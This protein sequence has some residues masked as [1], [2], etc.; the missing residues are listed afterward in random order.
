MKNARNISR[1]ILSISFAACVMAAAVSINAQEVGDM[2]TF[3]SMQSI[4][5]HQDSQ[6]EREAAGGAVSISLGEARNT[7][8][9]QQLDFFF[10]KQFGDDFSAFVDLEFQLSYSSEKHW[11][12]MSIQE[13]WMNYSLN[14]E[15]NVKLG[16]LFPAFNHFNEMKNR[17]ALQP[18]ILRPLVYERLLSS[19]FMT[20]DFIPEHAYAQVYG[21]IPWGPVFADYAL[22]MGNS[23]SSYISRFDQRDS[24]ITD[25]N[26]NFEFLSGVDPTDMSLKLFG[27]RIGVRT[28]NE[29]F[30]AGASI[31]HDANNMRRRYEEQASFI[32]AETLP[33]L[34]DDAGRFRFGGDLSLHYSGFTVEGEVIKVGYDLGKAEKL[35]FTLEQWFAYW[36][37]GYDI[38]DDL[39]PYVSMQ[40]G[41]YRFGVDADYF[42]ATTGL[43]WRINSAVTAKGQIVLYNER[44]DNL[45]SDGFEYNEQ[46]QI[47]FF[48]CGLSVML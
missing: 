4:F 9:L 3:G 47:L 35:N 5:F 26:G 21:W 23:E 31:T 28:R 32:S 20:E 44:A 25:L 48:L 15:L 12:S 45:R 46:L 33:L 6:L 14:D 43:S 27:G 7:F 24:I 29:Q 42:V 11:G 13:A 10:T 8:A 38:T 37:V 17:L 1:R 22:Y 30:K 36:V 18:Y 39:Y 40:W 2:Q 19:R 16:L 34:P 41:D